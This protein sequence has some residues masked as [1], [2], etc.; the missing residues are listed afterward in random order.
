MSPASLGVP[1]G[2]HIASI[3][4]GLTLPV[5]ISVPFG[6]PRLVVLQSIF[7]KVRLL[8]SMTGELGI[9]DITS[10]QHSGGA[11]GTIDFVLLIEIFGGTELKGN[12]HFSVI[13]PVGDSADTITAVI[14]V[15]GQGD[16]TFVLVEASLPAEVSFTLSAP[17]VGDLGWARVAQGADLADNVLCAGSRKQESSGGVLHFEFISYLYYNSQRQT[18]LNQDAEVDIA[19]MKNH[20]VARLMHLFQT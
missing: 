15:H 10:E 1:F 14:N 3:L 17:H 19:F 20:A 8:D 18:N 6:A 9:L 12:S 13:V 4:L 16:D 2:D 5:V 7:I 11:T